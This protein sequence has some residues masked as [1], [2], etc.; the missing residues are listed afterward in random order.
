[1]SPVA[2]LHA[3]ILPYIVPCNASMVA[4]NGT[5]AHK[6]DE[7]VLMS[8]KHLQ[9]RKVFFFVIRHKPYFSCSC[10]SHVLD[11]IWYAVTGIVILQTLYICLFVEMSLG[12]KILALCVPHTQLIFSNIALKG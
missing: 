6:L 8:I 5:Y 10:Y 1:M 7:S 3:F 2:A 12:R 9:L 11:W 4:V